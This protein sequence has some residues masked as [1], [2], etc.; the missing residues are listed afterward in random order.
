MS[1]SDA[2]QRR[3]ILER[4][5]QIREMQKVANLQ[6]ILNIALNVSVSAKD[7][8]NV[9]PDWFFSF[10]NLA[11]NIYSSPMQE[12]WGKIFAVE[13]SNPGSFSRRS[14]QT[15]ES[16]THRDAVTFSRAVSIASRRAGDTV[17]R[18][19]VGYHVR[20]GLLSLIR[21]PMPEQLNVSSFGLSYP[22]LLA[23]QDMKLLYASEIE[24]GE[25]AEGHQTQWRCGSESFEMTSR[26]A[27]V[28]LVYYKFTSVGAELYRLVGR[29]DNK[30]YLT[31]LKTIL[32]NVFIVQ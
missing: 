7:A 28:A 19:L 23:L 29:Q 25:F 24:S 31:A 17:P 27:G 3:K 8:E 6:S 4:R 32:N 13:V 2:S 22:D 1:T 10:C 26:R 14:L 16:L 18:I 30:A 11:E 21:R 12:L 9:D 15:L 5:Q 20:K